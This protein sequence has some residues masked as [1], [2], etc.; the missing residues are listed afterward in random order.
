MHTPEVVEK[1]LGNIEV[2]NVF[3]ITKIGAVA[4]CY[5]LD[6]LIS[7]NSKI[8]LIRDGV[9]VYSGVIDSLKRFKDDVKE[10]NTSIETEKQEAIA[11]AGIDAIKLQQIEHDNKYKLVEPNVKHLNISPLTHSYGYLDYDRNKWIEDHREQ[12][13]DPLNKFRQKLDW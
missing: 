11:Q 13:D 8:R 9:V 12:Y 7:R 1:I 2:R 10:V 5:V 6:G 3:K 4:G